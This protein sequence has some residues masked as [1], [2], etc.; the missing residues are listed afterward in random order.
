MDRQTLVRE[1]CPT[2]TQ[3]RLQKGALLLDVREKAEVELVSFDVPHI[4]QIPLSEFEERYIEIPK[5]RDV[6]LVCKEGIRSL[7]AAGFLINHGYSN[8]VNMK[9]GLLRWAQ[10][11]F[12]VKGD[13]SLLTPKETCCSDSGCC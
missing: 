6:V 12:P 2:T 4:L 7:R 13:T 5:N 9:Y 10:K 11:G 1:I 8:V 3:R